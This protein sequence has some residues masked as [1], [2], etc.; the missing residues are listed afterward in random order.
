MKVR[1]QT[2]LVKRGSVWYFRKKVPQDLRAHYGQESIRKSLKDY[3]AQADAKRQAAHLS[4][5]YEAEFQAVRQSSAPRP[6]VPLT[7]ELV[8]Q[9]SK[10][11]EG[12]ILTADEELRATGLDEAT[13]DQLQAETDAA[14]AE[15]RRAYA[16]GDSSPIDAAL[17]DW[18]DSLG[19]D[20]DRESDLFKGLRREFL[21]AR[22][23]ALDGQLARN[24]GE[25]V[26]TPDAPDAASIVPALPVAA[27]VRKGGPK[28]EDVIKYWKGV[29]QKSHRTT[30]TA[31]MLVKEFIALH[32]DLPLQD[33]TKAHF[34]AFR[35]QMLTRVKPATAQAR[36]NLLRAAYQV[37]LEDDQFGIRENP[38]QFV[39]I[40]NVETE[41]K[42][43]DAFTVDQLQALFDSPVFTA[44]ERPIGGRGDTSFWAPLV[45]LF[46]GAR[47]AE[48]L[49]L[50]TD[51]L[52]SVDGVMVFHFRHRPALGQRLKGKAKNNR[53]VPV[54]P[55]LIRLGLVEYLKEVTKRGPLP[56]GA[57][58]LFPDI[59]RGSKVRNLSSAWGAWFGRYLTRCGIKSDLL[60]FHS[61]RHT[62]KHF[63]RVCSIPEDHQDAMTGHTTAEVARRYGSADGY[64]VEALGRSVPLLKFGKLD[65]SRVRP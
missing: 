32:G 64:P 17:K 51:G 65:L 22:L 8:Q 59:D 24:R 30:G 5:H 44:G 14:A 15:I 9:L 25:L 4:G 20:T 56:D 62:F 43:R 27:P 58:W 28:L 31:D 46:T 54:H 37:C 52:Y 48:V 41:G 50:R 11:L 49:C 45:A 7:A 19:I 63:A 21:K 16:R 29:G 6:A 42:A 2:N 1:T 53:K 38:T 23:K 18:L 36:F 39:K 55:E 47:L 26:E 60:T 10:A 12:H 33:I 34:V 61:F 13:F 40:R 57:G 3:P 35:D